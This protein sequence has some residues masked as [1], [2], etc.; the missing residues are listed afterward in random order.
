MA[1]VTLDPESLSRLLTSVGPPAFT[2]ATCT[3]TTE[4]VVVAIHGLQSGF[5]IFGRPIGSI[6]AEIHL[7]A[8]RVTEHSVR[9]DWELGPLSGIPGPILRMLT[10]G[11]MVQGVIRKLLARWGVDGAVEVDAT[12]ALVHLERLPWT[13]HG[14]LSRLQCQRFDVPA[15]RGQALSAAFTLS[16]APATP[17][18]KHGHHAAHHGGHRPGG[19]KR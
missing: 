9:I 11:S 3:V 17:A 18:S 10:S 19:K 15:G 7:R 14:I 6:D 8:H 5:K 13:K 12:G 1:T 16:E 4:H 2:A